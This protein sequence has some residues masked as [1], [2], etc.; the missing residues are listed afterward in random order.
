MNSRSAV[1]KFPKTPKPKPESPKAKLPWWQNNASWILGLAKKHPEVDE[2]L[3]DRARLFLHKMEI[4]RHPPTEN[5]AAWLNKLA[6]WVEDTMTA[7]E[8]MQAEM[9]ADK[10]SP[11][12]PAA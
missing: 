9:R 1:I 10:T 7:L 2:L 3:N 12:P 6:D 8:A 11:E 4:W 5:Q